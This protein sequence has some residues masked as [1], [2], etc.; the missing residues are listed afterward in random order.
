MQKSYVLRSR[1]REKNSQSRSRSCPITG[2]LRNPGLFR[3]TCRQCNFGK[4]ICERFRELLKV[5]GGENS[6]KLGEWVFVSV[7]VIWI[8]S[9]CNVFGDSGSASASIQIRIEGVKSWLKVKKN[10]IFKKNL[11]FFKFMFWVWHIFGDFL[12]PGFTWMIF[13][14]VNS[15]TLS[16]GTSRMLVWGRVWWR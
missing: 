15:S 3:A 12:P 6:W 8:R 13:S 11:I 5:G 2:R 10:F 14:I 7:P 9:G 1:L 4:I 16:Y